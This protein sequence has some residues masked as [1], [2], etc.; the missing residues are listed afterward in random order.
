MDGSLKDLAMQRSK[1]GARTR[2]ILPP[3]DET[4]RA[5][6]TGTGTGGEA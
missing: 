3:T 2:G 5:G 1:T 4:S 6:A